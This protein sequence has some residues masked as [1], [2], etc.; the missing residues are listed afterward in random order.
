VTKHTIMAWNERH[1]LVEHVRVDRA[2]DDC[3]P[4]MS[5]V[6]R[7][8]RALGAKGDDPRWQSWEGDAQVGV[9]SGQTT[10]QNIDDLLE[11]LNRVPALEE[12]VDLDIDEFRRIKAELDNLRVGIPP[13]NEDSARSL[14]G[15]VAGIC[16]RAITAGRQRVPL[17]EQRDKAERERDAALSEAAKQ[18]MRAEIAEAELKASEGLLGQE[19]GSHNTKV[20]AMAWDYAQQVRANDALKV[21]LLNTEA[22]ALRVVCRAEKAEAELAELRKAGAS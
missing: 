6:H 8:Q 5:A 20:Q 11:R 4:V 15:V 10:E 14:Y 1:I 13:R 9:I 21:A 18:R 2:T 19:R 7:L 12:R 3:D 16:E 22:D 17:I